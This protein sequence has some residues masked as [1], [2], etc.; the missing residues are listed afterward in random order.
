[1]CCSYFTVQNYNFHLITIID[2]LKYQMTFHS[3]YFSHYTHFDMF[4]HKKAPSTA[5]NILLHP[6]YSLGM[7]K[8]QLH[9]LLH[10]ENEETPTLRVIHIS[11]REWRNFNSAGHTPLHPY[12]SSRIKKLQ[13]DESLLFENGDTSTLRVITLRAW[14][15]FNSTTHF[16]RMKKL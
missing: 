4:D 12:Y 3:N 7:K 14:R 5:I 1:M 11:L 2:I 15:N 13:L 9:E 10:F 8:L 16:S 6:C